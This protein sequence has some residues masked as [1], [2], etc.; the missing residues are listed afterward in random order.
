MQRAQDVERNIWWINLASPFANLY[1]KD[2][3]YGVNSEAWRMYHVERFI[4]IIIQIALTNGPDSDSSIGINEWGYRAAEIEAE[5]RKKAIES[6]VPFL[7]TGEL[8]L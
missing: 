6:L 5:I 3:R 4:D 7:Q 2:S 1:F 8:K